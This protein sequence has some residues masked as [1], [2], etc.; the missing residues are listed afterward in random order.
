MTDTSYQAPLAMCVSCG[1]NRE[2]A[3]HTKDGPICKKCYNIAHKD[4]GMCCGCGETKTLHKKVAGGRLCQGCYNQLVREKEPCRECGEL[5]LPAKRID[6][7]AICHNCWEKSYR[8]KEICSV[9]GRVRAVYNRKEMLCQACH[10]RQRKR[11]DEKYR[12]TCI[13]RDRMRSAFRR[14][15]YGSKTKSSKEYGIDYIQI[16]NHLGPCPGNKEEYEIDHIYPLVLFNLFEE[17]QV[18]AAFAPENHQWLPKSENKKKY[19][20]CDKKQFEEYLRKF[21]P[22]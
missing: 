3:E 5:S 10:N 22:V 9:C 4:V 19:C 11:V 18:R 14:G 21:R 15:G 13:L 6:G 8:T 7:H 2:V 16:I 12:L 20:K 17:Y 1:Q